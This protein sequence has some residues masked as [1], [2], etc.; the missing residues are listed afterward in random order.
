MSVRYFW[1]DASIDGRQTMLSGGP[2]SKDGGMDITIYQREDGGIKTAVRI[3]CRARG[4]RLVTEV[5]VGGE[6]VICGDNA[7]LQTAR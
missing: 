7:R 6:K 4:D 2:R 1:I 5:E 3:W